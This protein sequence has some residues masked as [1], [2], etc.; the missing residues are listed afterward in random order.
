MDTWLL[1]NKILTYSNKAI[2]I[3]YKVIEH[4]TWLWSFFDI[5]LLTFIAAGFTIFFG[6]QKISKKVAA[7]FGLSSN[8]IYDTHI[9]AVVLSNKRDN[10]LSIS[11]ISIRIGFKGL[12]N[13]KKFDT[14]LIL[15]GYD[16]VK[17]DLPLFSKLFKGADEIVIDI[18][19]EITFYIYTTSGT[20]ITCITESS[21]YLENIRDNIAKQ[22][23]I[24]NN[25]VLTDRMKYIFFYKKNGSEKHVIIDKT[26]FFND[27]NPFHFNMIPDFNKETFTEALIRFGYHRTFEN[28]ML[29]EID[30]KLQSKFILNK[31]HVQNELVDQN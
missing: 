7:S 9:P 24:L 29:F 21:N 16:A 2:M 6:Y 22:N 10:T 11:S 12:L 17:V 14:P 27:D 1:K 5:K 26:N 25:I 8:R 30:D 3:N 18:M 31:Q 23:V 15:K 28:Y 20:R 4:L 13:L 19:D